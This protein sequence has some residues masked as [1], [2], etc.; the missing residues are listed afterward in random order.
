MAGLDFTKLTGNSTFDSATEPRRIFAALPQKKKKYNYPRDV[1]SEVWEAWHER[2]GET[3]L[4]IKMNTGGG[5]TVVG[6]IALKSCLN[7]GVGPV[8]Y[9]A[10]DKSL[11]AQAHREALGLGLNVTD[12]PASAKFHQGR[13]ILITNIYK[14]FNGLS[15][16]GVKGSGREEL[17]LGAVLIDD[18]H[19][20]LATVES[21]FTL[22][23]PEEH[24]AYRELLDLFSEELSNQSRSAYLDLE[25]GGD[26]TTVLPVPF[27]A[28]ADKA[29][30]VTAI[31]HSHR[32]SEEIKF[33]W[34]F[35]SEFLPTCRAAVSSRDFE[36]APPCPPV[37]MIPSFARAQRRI[38]LTATLP[39]DSI[40]VTHFD[41]SPKSVETPI[42]PR[43][44]DDLGDRMILTPMRTFLDSDEPQIK[45]F[46][47]EQAEKHNVVVIVPSRA[48]AEAWQGQASAVHAADSLE[49]GLAALRD[50]HVGLV[51]LINKYDGIDLPGD[52]CRVLV[53]D[54]LP[55]AMGAL[56][57]LD[58]VALDGSEAML[59][60]Q[61]QR[62]E[63]GMGRGV[64]SN[65]DYCVVL[66]LG[67][68]LTARLDPASAREKFSP[69]TRAQLGL[70]DQVTELLEGKSFDQLQPVVD[71]CLG[72]DPAWV[73]ASRDVLDGV[74]YP[75]SSQVSPEA[76]A[77]REAFDLAA[78]DRFPQAA[79]RLQAAIDEM[80][81]PR[82]RG[83]MKQEAAS[84]LHRVDRVKAQDMQAS[85]FTDNRSLMRPR[86]AP[87]YVP[88]REP[89]S[90]AQSARSFLTH[91]YDTAKELALGVGALIE[92][93]EPD[94]RDSSVPFF[95]QA[96]KELAEHLG[97]A[98]QRP[99]QEMGR[100]PDD[101][102]LLGGLSFLVIEC[103][104]ASQS[105]DISKEDMAQLSQALDWFKE[106][107]DDTCDATPVLVH[108]S[109]YLHH[110]AS[111]RAGSRIMTF[112][113][114]ANLRDSAC[115]FA[116][117]IAID[118]AFRDADAIWRQLTALHLNG[119][120]FPDH[121]SVP[122]KPRRR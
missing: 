72:R 77:R 80:D 113:K 36:I 32:N 95:E 120:S 39:D 81:D 55:E 30:D 42:T 99:E 71:Q 66:L 104:S 86:A 57:H 58:S 121:W 60:R 117:A 2:R 4:V 91:R 110:Q 12:D 90:Q 118:D 49:E 33:A 111:A 62:I 23:I 50:R 24:P 44:A 51:V 79:K 18:A 78:A 56:D 92:Q 20:C 13:A 64:R 98:A 83:L 119:E 48:R 16:F 22:G 3:D 19:A 94:P 46:L 100:G 35:I 97:F 101:L 75:D 54:G 14:L 107:Y 61:V 93:L 102:W 65:D 122:P 115:E 31:L 103:K 41:A 47:A 9:I 114:L 5:K 29:D 10:P 59:I 6:L 105:E 76:V 84:Y 40:L 96:L 15:V 34:P 27:W 67:R 8:A 112:E 87:G 63:Q 68:R 53:L 38:Y 85:A 26:S 37:E 82:M 73:A 7:E 1:Q 116:S 52:A 28:W 69:A 74:E 109:R 89:A 21:Q 25:A 11:A 45:D 88:L 106:T 70:S 17:E 108:P 43:S